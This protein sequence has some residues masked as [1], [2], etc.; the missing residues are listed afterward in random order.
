MD[1]REELGTALD[2]DK[3][4]LDAVGKLVAESEPEQ[5]IVLTE[6]ISGKQQARLWVAAQG[7]RVALP[8]LVPPELGPLE[9]VTFHGKNSL[10]V[11]S[12]FQKRFCRP[13]AGIQ[14]EELWGFNYQPVSW[15]VPLIGPGY[16]VAHA[17]ENSLGGVA[18]DYRRV[19]TARPDG[20]PEIRE[21]DYRLSRF[22]F[23]G[24][25]D[26]LRRVSDHLLIGR[27]TRGGKPLPNYFVL[28]REAP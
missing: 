25:V 3:I 21:N 27:A 7:R 17:S 20:W 13:A 9:S 1:R 6:S 4:D 19:P 22:I 12:R 24:M 16:F 14:A 26:Y 28:C 15:L 23:N 5:R 11:F 8:E 18:I 10:A 2:A